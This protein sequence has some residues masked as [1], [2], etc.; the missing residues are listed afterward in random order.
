MFSK[1]FVIATMVPAALAGFAATYS[2][3]AAASSPCVFD[4][5]TPVSVQPYSQDESVGYG[6]YTFVKGAQLYIR[7]QPGLT[8]EWLALTLQKALAGDEACNPD[9]KPVQI[10]VTS[11]GNGFWVTLVGHDEKQADALIKWA[12]KVVADHA[13]TAAK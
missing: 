1:R 10:S 8:R 6:T 4:K 13:H 7:A 3:P 2:S 9:V 5:Y 12:K 11:A